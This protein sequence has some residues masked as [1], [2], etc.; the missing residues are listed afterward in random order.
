MVR[1]VRSLA[2]RTFQLC[3]GPVL[4][5]VGP[6]VPVEG[7]RAALRLLEEVRGVVRRV[8]GQADAEHLRRRVN[9]S[10][11]KMNN[12]ILKF[13]QIRKFLEIVRTIWQLFCQFGYSLAFS[14]RCREIL[15]NIHQ[16]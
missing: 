1:M 3:G 12:I 11:S 14:E 9:S 7:G 2:D 8:L 16:N 15:T 5:L 10:F 4:D 13:L 6:V